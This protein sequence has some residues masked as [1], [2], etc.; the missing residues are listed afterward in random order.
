MR[1]IILPTKAERTEPPRSSNPSEG[2]PRPR[3]GLK[4]GANA[5]A[6]ARP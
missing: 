3:L 5:E 2:N 1:K 6:R 4:Y